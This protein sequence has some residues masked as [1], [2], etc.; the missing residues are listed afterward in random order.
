MRPS[1]AV[2][3]LASVLILSACGTNRPPPDVPRPQP[4]EAMQPEPKQLCQLR[5]EIVNLD[6]AD[7]LA[8]ILN[9]HAVDSEQYR[10]LELKHRVLGEWI[11]GE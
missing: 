3:S 5:P 10:R 11:R 2:L 8:L 7:A 1:L 6:M 4:V 9:C